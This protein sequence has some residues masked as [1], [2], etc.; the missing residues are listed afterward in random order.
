MQ[1]FSLTDR[2]YNREQFKIKPSANSHLQI[3]HLRKRIVLSVGNVGDQTNFRLNYNADLSRSVGEP[4]LSSTDGVDKAKGPNFMD[5]L[6]LCFDNLKENV[7]KGKEVPGL[8]NVYAL[9]SP[10]PLTLNGLNIAR[11]NNISSNN[12]V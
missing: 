2:L 10:P 3:C 5:D 8:P 1:V 9:N 4:R 6:R 11:N 12:V 7:L